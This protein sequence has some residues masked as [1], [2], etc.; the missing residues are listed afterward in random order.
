MTIVYTG[1]GRDEELK[2]IATSTAAWAIYNLLLEHIAI[3]ELIE[4]A[5]P[6]WFLTIHKTAAIESTQSTT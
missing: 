1:N 4:A 6:E 3:E 5:M 2:N